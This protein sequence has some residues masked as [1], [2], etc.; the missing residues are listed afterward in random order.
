MTNTTTLPLAVLGAADPEMTAIEAV[1]RAAGVSYLYADSAPGVRVHAGNAYTVP[2]PQ[3]AIQRARAGGEIWLVEC[4]HLS[5]LRLLLPAADANTVRARTVRVD[6]HDQ[7][8]P[9]YGVPPEDFLPGSSLGQVVARVARM[10][11]LPAAWPRCREEHDSSVAEP[12]SGSI[13]RGA[14]PGEDGRCDIVA[15]DIW[16]VTTPT[17]RA[18][19]IPQ[20]LVLAAAADHC[21]AAAYRGECPGVDPES[22]AA[23]RAETRAA[24][25]GRPVAEVL[26]DVEKA[27]AALAAAPLVMLTAGGD[28]PMHGERSPGVVDYECCPGAADLVVRDLRGQEIPEL[29]EAACQAGIAF[30]ATPRPGPD[31]RRKV[32]LQCATAAQL[33]AWPAWAE[34][35]GITDLYGGDPAR[36]FAGGYLRGTEQQ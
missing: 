26:R 10:D 24:H 1:L 19:A 4:C 12:T 20:A 5:H 2:L 30:L 18:I 9:G 31:G 27:K 7:G 22:L 25:Q 21:L 6:H 35:H 11:R 15:A 13:W 28:C 3:I 14:P 34:A 36:G 17:S 8:D 33:A 29:P 16:L 32:V 23:W